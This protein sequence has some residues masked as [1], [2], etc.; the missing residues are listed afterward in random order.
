LKHLEIPGGFAHD[1]EMKHLKPTRPNV[2]KTTT[3]MEIN[4]EAASDYAGPS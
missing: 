2:P 4:D 3:V 1:Y